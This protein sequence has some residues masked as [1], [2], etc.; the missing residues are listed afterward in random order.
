MQI[1][2]LFPH[3]SAHD[4]L[5]AISGDDVDPVRLG[6]KWVAIVDR[7]TMEELSGRQLYG[8]VGPALV[9]DV[10]AP[11]NGV[12]GFFAAEHGGKAMAWMDIPTTAQGEEA[13]NV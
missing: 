5:D 13:A 2:D 3:L 8:K 12:L 4:L 7:D 9:F 6:L 1:H 10:V 11:G